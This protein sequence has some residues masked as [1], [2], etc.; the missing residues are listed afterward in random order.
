MEN[1]QEASELEHLAEDFSEA[2]TQQHLPQAVALVAALALLLE[3]RLDLVVRTPAAGCSEVSL[4][5]GLV[6]QLG[7]GLVPVLALELEL[8]LELALEAVLG[9][10]LE[11]QQELH[12]SRPSRLPM[13][14]AAPRSVPLLKR[15]QPLLL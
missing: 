6:V 9:Q 7:Q 12:F 13:A 8:E 3:A 2:P 1:L 5:E 4:Q 15:T 11:V 14:L 10:G